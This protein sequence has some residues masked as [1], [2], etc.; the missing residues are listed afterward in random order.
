VT[1]IR[2]CRCL[3]VG[4]FMFAG[5]LL[6]VSI[7]TF[8]PVLTRFV[9]VDG[10]LAGAGAT[11]GFASLALAA[12]AAAVASS[13]FA[14]RLWRRAA[15]I[16]ARSVQFRLLAA[17]SGVVVYLLLMELGVRVAFQPGAYLSGDPFW[18]H[19]FI[20]REPDQDVVFRSA[21]PINRHDPELGWVPIPG[22][23]SESVHVNSH[24]AR[25]AEEYPLA[26]PA[27]EKRIVVVG[28]SFTFGEGVPDDDV[29][30]ALLQRQFDGVRVIN[31]GV[32]GYGTDQQYLRL[33]RD[34]F[35]FDPDQVIL[36]FFGP[37]AERNVLSFRDSAKPMFRLEADGIRLVNV[38]VPDP[39]DAA[40]TLQDPLP[41]L[42]LGSLLQ[43]MWRRGIGRT[44]LAPQWEVTRRILDAAVDAARSRG[45]P[46]LLVYF[47]DK[48]AS[49]W[50]TPHDTEIVLSRWAGERRVRFLS[51]RPAFLRLSRDDQRRV[52][53]G[54]YT[55]FGNRVV[56]SA[57][58]EEIRSSGIL[59]E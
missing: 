6:A 2:L 3:A 29:Y 56:A 46:F 11:A 22:H 59:G 1:S 14:R 51:L 26:K 23:A 38:P 47:P 53:H 35:A 44:R 57:I 5:G 30:T 41:A 48:Q 40:T 58:A 21:N 9:L 20:E 18:I 10:T 49:F 33:R 28:D 55:P 17:V 8:P 15:G 39:A 43:T 37:N 45:V 16:D 32:L 4:G 42:R 25:G 52:W 7:L 50:E 54:H 27:G 12:L 31:L 13:W 36:A 24:G 34:G 19:R